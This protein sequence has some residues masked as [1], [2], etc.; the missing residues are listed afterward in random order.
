MPEHPDV[1]KRMSPNRMGGCPGARHRMVRKE[2]DS[3]GESV[4]AHTTHE[5]CPKA[6]MG[7]Y[8]EGRNT[9]TPLTAP[10]AL[11]PPRKEGVR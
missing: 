2:A 8:Y 11:E 3:S 6:P 7:L 10:G 4:T 9:S 1:A 5:T